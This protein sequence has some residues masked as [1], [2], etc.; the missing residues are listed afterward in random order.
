M[1]IFLVISYFD[2]VG[3][4]EEQLALLAVRLAQLGHQVVVFTRLPVERSNQYAG[5]ILQEHIRVAAPPGWLAS[6]LGD[7]YF[8]D[9]LVRGLARAAFPF[10]LP[11]AAAAALFRRQPF[12]AAY[13][14]AAGRLRRFMGSLLYADR[15]ERLLEL[16]LSQWA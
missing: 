2:R 15:T 10:L 4:S 12:Q 6:L 8:Q 7:W 5:R 3:G 9:R 11:A 1:R 16:T 13:A 14:S